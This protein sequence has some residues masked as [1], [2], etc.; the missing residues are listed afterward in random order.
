MADRTCSIDGCERTFRMRSGMC[1]THYLR[2]RRHGTTEL[3]ERVQLNHTCSVAGCDAK[4][5]ARGLCKVHYLRTVQYGTLSLRPKYEHCSVPKCNTKVRSSGTPY[6]ERHY[7]RIRRNGHFEFVG[8]RRTD[9]PTY[10]TVHSRLQAECGPAA[11]HRCVDCGARAVDWSYDNSDPNQ[12]VEPR[13]GCA[14][15]LDLDHYAP[16]CKRCHYRLDHHK[17]KTNADALR[18]KR[19]LRTANSYAKRR[20]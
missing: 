8:P 10:R 5:K 1:N 15:S 19:R 13:T 18:G 16:R 4:H 7:G 17:A 14:Y 3:P 2:L 6:C 9:D 12:R 11:D 20:A